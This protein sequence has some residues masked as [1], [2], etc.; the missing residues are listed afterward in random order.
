[1]DYFVNRGQD[2]LPEF[3]K[4]LLDKKLVPE[5]KAAFFAYWASKFLIF[6]NNNEKLNHEPACRQT[7]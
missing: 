6:S 3:Q 2:A 7:G 5:N 1:M 4:F